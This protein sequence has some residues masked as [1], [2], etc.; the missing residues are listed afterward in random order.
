MAV[1]RASRGRRG[2][3]TA[4]VNIGD[5]SLWRVVKARA[6]SEAGPRPIRL[7]PFNLLDSGA[8]LAVE[9][10][11]PFGAG[12]RSPTV[13]IA[14]DGGMAQM[15][16]LHA[17]RVRLNAG[18]SGLEVE[19]VGATAEEERDSLLGRHPEPN[20]ACSLTATRISPEDKQLGR[21][22]R[23]AEAVFVGYK[24]EAVGLAAALAFRECT[25]RDD[26]PVV[27]IVRESAGGAAQAAEAAGV[28]VFGLFS[29][30]LGDEFLDRGM[31]EVMARAM[32]EEYVSAQT[33]KGETLEQNPSL[34]PWEEL[35]S[36]LRQSN[37]RAVDG[38]GPRLN[39]VGAVVVPSP[40]VQIESEGFEFTDEEL[41]RLAELEHERWMRDLTDEGWAHREGPKDPVR[42]R[43]PSLVPWEQLSEE[44]R[45]KDRDAVLAT[46]RI[47]RRA[48][49]AIERLDGTDG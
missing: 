23:D 18:G 13:L 15:L 33:A 32:H 8:S 29:E 39:E 4:F 28:R 20:D 26:V 17:A 47:L 10:A 36:S 6:L 48:G 2:V 34:V 7:E 44:E 43:H 21:R 22:A 25:R 9:S 1:R 16:A 11:D 12:E 37:R 35:P 27:L 24:D 5:P 42:K 46:P 14:G 40:L 45:Q 19:L 38:I 49:Y 31:N 3:L 30:A 41:E